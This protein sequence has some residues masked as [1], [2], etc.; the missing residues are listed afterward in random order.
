MYDSMTIISVFSNNQAGVDFF[1][2]ARIVDSILE[3]KKYKLKLTN[4]NKE[5]LYHLIKKDI[6]TSQKKT[7]ILI[8]FILKEYENND[9]KISLS[10]IKIIDFMDDKLLDAILELKILDGDKSEDVANYLVLLENNIGSLVR[11][12]SGGMSGYLN[13]EYDEVTVDLDEA[14]IEEYFITPPS[15]I[16][17]RDICESIP[18]LKA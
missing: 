12:P 4:D 3:Y 11:H 7:K 1:G 17:I 5:T 15:I 10:V 2:I 16:K 9:K 13:S 6:L 18:E 14:K 8:D